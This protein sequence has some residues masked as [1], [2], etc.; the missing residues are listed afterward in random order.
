MRTAGGTRLTGSRFGSMTAMPSPVAIHTVPSAARTEP[1]PS[2]MTGDP[3]APV[4]GIVAPEIDGMRSVAHGLLEFAR[5]SREGS[6][7]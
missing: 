2:T 4:G 5:C 6:R 3:G 7:S 1:C